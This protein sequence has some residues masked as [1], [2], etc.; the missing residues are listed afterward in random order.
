MVWCNV[1]WVMRDGQSDDDVG[2][3]G[4]VQLIIPNLQPYYPSSPTPTAAHHL[5]SRIA[6]SISFIPT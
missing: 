2:S 3:F 4:M 6:I 1:R 5:P